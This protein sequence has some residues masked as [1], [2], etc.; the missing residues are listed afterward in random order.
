MICPLFV[1]QLAV[2]VPSQS[3]P[4]LKARVL[5]SKRGRAGGAQRALLSMSY[6]SIPAGRLAA[7]A[8]AASG[9]LPPVERSPLSVPSVG[10]KAAWLGRMSPLDELAARS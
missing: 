2:L 5:L 1:K 4:D 10:R 7:L 6:P 8:A 3:P 9:T